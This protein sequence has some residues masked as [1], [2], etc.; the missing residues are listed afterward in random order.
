MKSLHTLVLF[1]FKTTSASRRCVTYCMSKMARPVLNYYM[2]WANASWTYS[3]K[4]ESG[5]KIIVGAWIRIPIKIM[6]NQNTAYVRVHIL[7]GT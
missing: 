6:V 4:R 7:D 2:K 1:Q 3:I 5:S